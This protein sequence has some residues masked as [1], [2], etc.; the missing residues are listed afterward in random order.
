MFKN[1]QVCCALYLDFWLVTTWFDIIDDYQ[2][3]SVEYG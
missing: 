3:N 2:Q 1:L